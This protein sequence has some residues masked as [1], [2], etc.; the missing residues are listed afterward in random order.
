VTDIRDVARY[1]HRHYEE[2]SK[3]A[4]LRED[5]GHLQS[6]FY[7]LEEE[8]RGLRHDVENCQTVLARIDNMQAR[9]L[10]VEEETTTALTG[11][12][13][14]VLALE[15]HFGLGSNERYQHEMN[16]AAAQLA[17]NNQLPKT[18]VRENETERRQQEAEFVGAVFGEDD[19]DERDQT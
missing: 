14:R 19:S 9:M 10:E 13:V 4:G 11:L 7:D 8:I 3:V 12:L 6:N 15:I 2:E 17:M 18:L 1:D 5:L 16:V